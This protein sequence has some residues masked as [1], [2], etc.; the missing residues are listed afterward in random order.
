M[1]CL[2]Y[3]IYYTPNNFVCSLH[4]IVVR[5]CASDDYA[6]TRPRV[7][8]SVPA[9]PGASVRRPAVP[10]RPPVAAPACHQIHAAEDVGGAE[11]ALL[12][13]LGGRVT[14]AGRTRHDVG[15]AV[16]ADDVGV[17][18]AVVHAVTDA[19]AC[20]AESDS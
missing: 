2:I 4:S 1:Y 7:S 17:G 16:G 9:T 3:N 20:A 5:V 18:V 6:L 13:G 14:R 11:V 10:P 12:V 19:L 8:R 15:V